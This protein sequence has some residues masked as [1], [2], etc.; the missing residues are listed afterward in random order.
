[1]LANA[2]GVGGNVSYLAR[3]CQI[4]LAN[5][6]RN[7]VYVFEDA[8]WWI[9]PDAA[10]QAELS[11]LVQDLTNFNTFQGQSIPN[12]DLHRHFETQKNEVIQNLLKVSNRLETGVLLGRPFFDNFEFIQFVHQDRNREDQC[13]FNYKVARGKPRRSSH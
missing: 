13:Y 10:T 9:Y 7:E 4:H 5:K 3:Q 12:T 8:V 6:T 1:M 2:G 11:K